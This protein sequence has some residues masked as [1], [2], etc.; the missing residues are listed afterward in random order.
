[1]L[2]YYPETISA[3]DRVVVVPSDTAATATTIANYINERQAQAIVT[4]YQ[5]DT[6]LGQGMV[7]SNDGW[8]VM[9]TTSQVDAAQLA[10]A[11]STGEK[12][13][14][15]TVVFDEVHSMLYLKVADQNLSLVNFS[16]TTPIL[17]DVVLAYGVGPK[18]AV[19]YIG[20]FGT[21]EYYLD[22]SIADTF[23]GAPAFDRKGSAIGVVVDNQTILPIQVVSAAL[24]SLFQTGTITH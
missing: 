18:V 16:Q 9:V 8:C 14:V 10:V 1:M 2:N 6:L 11:F 22:R 3:F 21:D 15:T 12:K 24:E 19:G 23:I 13:S 5:T 17:G 7:V 4:I 20:Q